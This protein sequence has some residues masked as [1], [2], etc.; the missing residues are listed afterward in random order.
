MKQCHA[1][2]KL[3]LGLRLAGRWERDRTQFFRYGVIVAS[4]A[5]GLVGA[6]APLLAVRSDLFAKPAVLTVFSALTLAA[7]ALWLRLALRPPTWRPVR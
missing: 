6:L 5:D 4:L 2:L 3:I 1:S 7:C